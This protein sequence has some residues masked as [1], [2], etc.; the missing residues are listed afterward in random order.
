MAQGLKPRR[1]GLVA[2]YIILG[3]GIVLLVGLPAFGLTRINRATDR[4]SDFTATTGAVEELTTGLLQ[5]V[6][7]PLAQYGRTR[8][9]V[10]RAT[11]IEAIE[12]ARAQIAA[13]EASGEVVEALGLTA[14]V[15]TQL[16]DARATVAPVEQYLA[17]IDSGM[18]IGDSA[19]AAQIVGSATEILQG[20]SQFANET[21]P[22]ATRLDNDRKEALRDAV[23]LLL[24]GV[25]V[26]VF[27][28]LGLGALNRMRVERVFVAET[29]RRDSAERLAAHRADVVNMASHELRNPLTALTL[30]SQLL[31]R[32]ADTA[33]PDQIRELA[34][35]AHI[36]ALRCNALVNELLDLGRLDAD[37]LDLRSGATPLKPVLA[38]SVAMSEAHH[39]GRDVR[40]SGNLDTAVHA[41]PD[42]LRV[43][44]RNL[45]D[46]AFKYSPPE[47]AVH[48]SVTE[49]GEKVR[50]DIR[51]EG[52]GVPEQFR[53]RIFQRFER[54]AAP[55]HASGVGIGLFLSRE[56]AR[57]MNGDIRYH[58][59]ERGAEF[60]LELPVAA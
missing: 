54:L 13:I 52:A 36:A 18:Q 32:S 11:S 15:E 35:D 7:G 30:S 19:A 5:L 55:G 47:T 29:A 42:R 57:R 60:E 21:R 37:R 38:D 6:T 34:E 20:R 24:L 28:V 2:F 39:G 10:V 8:D 9:P 59:R 49:V 26:F 45:V 33:E 46:N 31:V 1:R 43:I 17:D 53:E 3:L 48:I 14:P 51:D 27:I 58:P 56:L 40:F 16:E 25:A 44:L 41:D 12:D 4:S 22:I 50:I 23:Y